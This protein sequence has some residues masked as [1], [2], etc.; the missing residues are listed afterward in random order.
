MVLIEQTTYVTRSNSEVSVVLDREQRLKVLYRIS[1]LINSTTSSSTLLRRVLRETLK[2]LRCVA[3]SVALLEEKEE[4]LSPAALI[5]IDEE[6]DELPW[7]RQMPI[8]ASVLREGEPAAGSLPKYRW[9]GAPLKVEGKVIGA[10]VALRNGT[11]DFSEEDLNLLAAIANQTA[12]MVQTSRLYSRLTEQSQ[13]L[14]TLF[15]VGQALISPEPLPD[16]LNR[17][18]DSLLGLVDDVKQCSVLLINDSR[19]M[20]LSAT[21]GAGRY[22]Q[23]PSHVVPENLLGEVS[24]RRQSVQV[25]EVK[26]PARRKPGKAPKKGAATTLLSIPIHFQETLVGLLNV[27][28]SKAREFE[29]DDMR[30]LNSFASLCGIAIENARRYERVLK[31]EESIRMTDRL[32]TLGTLSAEIAHEIRNPVTIITMLMHSLREEGAIVSGRGKDVSLIL[33]KLE[34]INRI[35]SQVLGFAKRKGPRLE[36]VNLNEVLEEVL[37]LV[38]HSI[39]ARNIMVHRRLAPDLARVLVDRGHMDQVVLNLVLNAIE[40]MPGGGILTV[41]SL[42]TPPRKRSGE[43]PLVRVVVRDTGMGISQEMQDQLFQPFVT[44]RQEGVGLGLFVSQK[45]L[46]QYDGRIAVRS[47]PGEGAAFAVSLPVASM[48]NSR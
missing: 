38:Q 37:F 27:Y 30:L 34:K 15:Q 32:A 10:L 8:H 36:W 5:Q 16:I 7:G 46:A 25:F 31:A 9:L 21:G 41:E 17:I 43:Q 23:R 48:E 12:R 33:E 18:T 14:E 47:K 6:A 45:L 44:G 4:K 13:R 20:V 35:V 2:A 3:G 26:R 29:A 40:A 22:V 1:D 11:D 42:L 24:G 28:A 39:S 19:E